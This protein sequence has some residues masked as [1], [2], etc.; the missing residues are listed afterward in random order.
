MLVD[1]QYFS[2]FIIFV[3]CTERYKCVSFHA[4]LSMTVLYSK[5]LSM[6]LWKR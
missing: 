4:L 6:Q 3:L 1:K 5:R 2:L